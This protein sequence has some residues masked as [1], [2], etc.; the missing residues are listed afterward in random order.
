MSSTYPKYQPIEDVENINRY[1]LGGYHP[2]HIDDRLNERYRI[3]DKLG[4]G[5]FST[6]WLAVDEQTTKYVA[7]K[8]GTSDADQVEFDMLSQ[9]TR[10]PLRGNIWKTNEM[11]I[12]PVI[13]HFRASGPNGTHS[14]L[15]TPP[16]RCNLRDV[17][18]EGCY[19][20]LQLDAA[21]S[22]AAQ[23][24][25]A[26]SLIHDRGYAHGDLH[27]GNLLLQ[28]HVPI[29]GVSVEQ[30][31]ARYSELE[32]HPVLCI[33]LGE[34]ATDPS[35]PSYA[36]PPLSFNVPKDGIA[37]GEA[38]LTLCD[39][40]VAFRPKDKSRF[41]AYTPR[42]LCP[43][44]AL[45]EPETP[46]TFA[47]DIWSL[48]CVVFELFSNLSLFDRRLT[49]QEYITAQQVQILG[50]MPPAWWNKWEARRKWCDEEGRPLRESSK[51]D[52]L[53]RRFQTCVQ[54]PRLE[55]G[56]DTLAEDELDALMTLLRSML[57]WSPSERL[58]ISGV[59]RSNWMTHWALPAY[60]KCLEKQKHLGEE[61]GLKEEK[62]VKEDR[63]LVVEKSLEQE[64]GLEEESRTEEKGLEGVLN[65]PD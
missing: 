23:L 60:Q 41:E 7:I 22:L 43:P 16:A 44:E 57:A 63:G 31:H 6:V 4:H 54:N 59:L 52:T 18:G 51:P 13:D 50:P 26:L 37:I 15:V 5:S 12:H 64:K 27:L 29:D 47:S 24:V 61:E 48:G 38:L 2:I 49:K 19:H 9:V 3:V 21:R 30:M 32:K 17:K 42:E 34:P 62:G 28:L 10:S 46:L 40:G 36:V 65:C 25:I 39:F 8:V 56:W 35:V 11:L 33:K 1:R 58:D 45:F 55:R 20:I 53:K 14:C